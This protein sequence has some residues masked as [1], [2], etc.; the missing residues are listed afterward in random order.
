MGLGRPVALLTKPE[1]R[2]NAMG[3]YEA[4]SQTAMAAFTSLPPGAL[5][6]H[7]GNSAATPW[8]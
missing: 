6:H 2:S 3:P 8:L 7:A 5:A 4:G 1:G